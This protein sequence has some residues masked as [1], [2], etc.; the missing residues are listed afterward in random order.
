MLRSFIA[1]AVLF[2][3]AGSAQA[4]TVLTAASDSAWVTLTGSGDT[5]FTK[6]GAAS[7]RRGGGNATGDWEFS[8]VGATDA[9]IG[10]AGQIAWGTG[11]AFGLPSSGAFVSYAAG[12]L[13]TLGFDRAGER[14]HAANVGG[15]VDTL[16]IRARANGSTAASFQGLTLAFNG[17][18]VNLGNLIGD[19]NAEYVGYADARLT[20]GFALA[21]DS[22]AFAPGANASA[23]GGSTTMLQVKVGTSPMAAVPEPGTWALMIGGFGLTGA[24]LRRRRVAAFVRT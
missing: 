2:A 10:T 13:M 11:N 5:Q 8:I 22:A 9:P 12:G 19:S 1:A 24:A 7:V 15:G 6:Q 14:S 21:F 18:T 4:G 17:G 20:Q 16:W 3:V 23:G